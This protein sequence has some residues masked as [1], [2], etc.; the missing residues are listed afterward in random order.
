MES[1]DLLSRLVEIEIE[2][3]IWNGFPFV[4]FQY[5]I[6]L[7]P[8][9]ERCLIHMQNLLEIIWMYIEWNEW[10]SGTNKWKCRCIFFFFF[11]VFKWKFSRSRLRFFQLNGTVD[12][13]LINNKKHRKK[14]FEKKIYK[15]MC[16][17]NVYCLWGTMNI[18]I[19][20]LYI[21]YDS[22]EIW[23]FC[24]FCFDVFKRENRIT[25]HYINRFIIWNYSEIRR[26]KNRFF[27]SFQIVQ[28][29]I[30]EHTHTSFT[31]IST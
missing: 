12:L 5:K 11:F 27:V 29:R 22:N 14:P 4:V 17:I 19:K 3:I 28:I 31:L 6:K 1:R 30:L 15:N 24:C 18:S 9:K 10:N 23:T 7:I 20:N 16:T 21:W 13:N 8:H 26:G 25:V 2:I